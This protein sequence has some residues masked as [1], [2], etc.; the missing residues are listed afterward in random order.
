MKTAHNFSPDFKITALQ[1]FLQYLT[2]TQ[3]IP[4]CV[5]DK[6]LSTIHILLYANLIIF[7]LSLVKIHG[8]IL[9]HCKWVLADTKKLEYIHTHYIHFFYTIKQKEIKGV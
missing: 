1:A 6:L 8:T 5:N 7:L 2:E 4:G 3:P 9:L